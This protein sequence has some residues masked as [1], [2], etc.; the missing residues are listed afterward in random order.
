MEGSVTTRFSETTKYCWIIFAGCCALNLTVAS[1]H[2]MLFGVYLLPTVVAS[3]TDIVQASF[4]A[5]I[6]QWVFAGAGLIAGWLL[7]R[8]NNTQFKLLTIYSAIMLVGSQLWNS[9]IALNFFEGMTGLYI[10][11][12]I[13]GLSAGILPVMIPMIMIVSWFAPKWR[14][15]FVGFAAVFSAVGAMIWPPVIAGIIQSVGLTQAYLFHGI[16][17]LVFTFPTTIFLFKKRP[18][19]ILPWGVKTWE[20]LRQQEADDVAKYGYPA[21]KVFFTMAMWL[22]LAAIAVATFHGGFTQ[23]MP[24]AASQWLT[25]AG[26]PDGAVRGAMVG[27]LMISCGAGGNLISKLLS[28]FI[29]DKWGPGIASASFVFAS[30]LGMLVFIFVP[31]SDVSLYAGA[32][33]LGCASP[34]MTVGMPMCV[35]MIFGDRTFPQIQSY[36]GVIQML[37]GG[38]ATVGVALI[39]TNFG[40]EYVSIY[41]FG[42]IIYFIGTIIFIFANRFVGKYPWYDI[43]GKLM[44]K[45]GEVPVQEPAA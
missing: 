12:V 45:V 28:G 26:D 32:F 27:A 30:M 1:M 19:H 20:E 31:T 10:G 18:E 39:L 7:T 38:V 14:G 21:K 25:Q 23:N 2:A 6:G 40:G 34:V 36:V 37:V 16:V 35:R 4:A 8:V 41:I 44:P 15:R 42:T 11:A 17:L 43:N 29:I 3:G 9:F 22:L 33:L 5:T 13:N 24:G